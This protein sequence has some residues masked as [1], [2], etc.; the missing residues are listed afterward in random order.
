MKSGNVS[1]DKNKKKTLLTGAAIA[2]RRNLKYFLLL[3]LT[4]RRNEILQAKFRNTYI[5]V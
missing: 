4:V 5:K 3:Y 2:L 1:L